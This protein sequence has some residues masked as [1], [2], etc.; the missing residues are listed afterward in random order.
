MYIKHVL[1]TLIGTETAREILRTLG[2]DE[3]LVAFS[4]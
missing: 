1:E 3:L 2:A 4:S